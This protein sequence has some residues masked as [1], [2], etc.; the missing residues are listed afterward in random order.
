M[1]VRNEGSRDRAVRI[2]AGV[3]FIAGA[4][5]VSPGVFSVVLLAAGAVALATGV[6][7]WCPLYAA[8][9]VSTAKTS[10]GHV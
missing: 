4:W 6:I 1:P 5:A 7:G 10:R 8:C 9:D 2:V 3:L